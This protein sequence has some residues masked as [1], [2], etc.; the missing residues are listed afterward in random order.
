VG[1]DTLLS[2]E[3]FLRSRGIICIF[4]IK[5]ERCEDEGTTVLRNNTLCDTALHLR[6]PGFS[7]NWNC[8]RIHSCL[9]VYTVMCHLMKGM[10]PE[11]CVVRRFGRCANVIEC[12]YTN[13]EF[14]AY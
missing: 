8:S 9:P 3:L 7:D 6:R 4:R 14:I 12:T 5:L 1:C 10:R 13:L 11:K 2:G